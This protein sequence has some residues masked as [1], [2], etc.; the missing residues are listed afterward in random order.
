MCQFSACI[1]E[2]FQH[3]ASAESEVG[4]KALKLP[5]GVAQGTAE[6]SFQALLPLKQKNRSPC[7]Q[8]LCQNHLVVRKHLKNKEKRVFFSKTPDNPYLPTFKRVEIRLGNSR[9]W[10]KKHYGAPVA[11]VK[12]RRQTLMTRA[13]LE[14]AEDSA[15]RPAILADD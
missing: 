5:E 6:K 7:D 10:L 2:L 13:N 4:V 12:V 1:G 11:R 3:G 15:Q 8:A 9:A 14:L